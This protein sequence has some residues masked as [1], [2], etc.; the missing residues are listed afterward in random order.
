MMLIRNTFHAALVSLLFIMTGCDGI[1]TGE[2]AQTITLS[3][4]P[5]GSYGPVTLSLTADMAPVAINFRAEHG[6]DPS[7]IGK[8]NAYRA[9]LNQDGREIA[10]SVFNINHTGSPDVPSGAPYLVQTLM[11]LESGGSGD[12]ELRITPT[13]PVEV[14]LT[15]TQ[16]E[17]RRNVRSGD[18]VY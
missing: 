15:D 13:K 7:E 4:Q 11:T 10:A 17:I 6:D 2:H 5:D 3:E 14:K 12:Y 8:W 18:A 16:I 9:T 1:V